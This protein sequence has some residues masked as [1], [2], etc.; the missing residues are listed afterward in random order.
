MYIISKAIS[1]FTTLVDYSTC[2]AYT[3]STAS[4]VE[5]FLKQRN[6]CVRR[7]HRQIIAPA[8]RVIAI[9]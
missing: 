6:F 3:C 5:S 4:I 9:M 1:V 2:A 8:S 7:R